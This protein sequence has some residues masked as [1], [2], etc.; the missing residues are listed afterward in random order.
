M[1]VLAEF[2]K[3]ALRGNLVEMAIGFTVGAAFTTVAKSIVVDLIMPVVGLL[4]GGAD[5]RD[6]FV[7][8]SP[9]ETAAG[10]YETLEA[11]QSAGAVTWNYGVFINNLFAFMLVAIIMFSAR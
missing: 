3:F 8:L 10:P 2:Q 9:G 5:F 6:L 7:V 4:T 11:A 1:S